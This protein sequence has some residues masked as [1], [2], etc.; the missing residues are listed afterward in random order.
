MRDQ[1]EN[2]RHLV[3]D[4]DGRPRGMVEVPRGGRVEAARGDRIW[5][6]EKDDF[7]VESVVRYLVEWR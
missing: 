6:I 1:D 7:D 3:F 5:V 4:P 2:R